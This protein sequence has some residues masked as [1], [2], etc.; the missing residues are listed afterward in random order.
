MHIELSPEIEALLARVIESGGFENPQ[1][2]IETSLVTFLSAEGLGP[3]P[4]E[5]EA[6][7]AELNRSLEE[8]NTEIE[9]GGGIAA[10]PEFFEDIVQ[11]ATRRREARAKHP[12]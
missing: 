4:W 5:R 2:A 12:A 1:D 11:R 3:A 9:E 7:L 6:W 10:T 8:A